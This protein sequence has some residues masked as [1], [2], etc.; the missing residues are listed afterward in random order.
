MYEIEKN[1]L[2]N[3]I[4]KNTY[5][6]LRRKKCYIAGGA[7]TSLFTNHEINDID[8]Y[9]RDKDS[10][11]DLILAWDNNSRRLVFH[12]SKSTTFVFAKDDSSVRVQF[13]NFRFFKDVNEIFDSFDFTVCMGAFDFATE[14]FIFHPDFMRHNAQRILKFNV[15]TSFPIV[16]VFRTQKYQNK[17]YT[18]PSSEF[19]RIILSAM[20]LNIKTW[21]ELED[22]LGGMYGYQ[23]TE[24]F[25]SVEGK[26]FNLSEAI[27][28]FS[29]MDFLYNKIEGERLFDGLLED[30]IDNIKGI[31]IHYIELRNGKRCR[32]STPQISGDT[33][34]QE[35]GH[36]LPP[37]FYKKIELQ[38]FL[39]TEK[40][41]KFVSKTKNPG[42]F[43]SIY[44][45]DFEYKIGEET[46][47]LKFMGLF[48]NFLP[49]ISSS[50]YAKNRYSVSDRVLIEA[51]FD[52]KDIV[53]MNS[54]TVIIKKCI[55]IREVPKEE[56]IQYLI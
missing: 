25:K 1:K 5:E 13:I 35:M 54:T 49:A 32:V 47:D 40:L 15:N 37:P 26:Q 44:K 43:T 11:I 8:V 16:S 45:P 3:Y 55:P 39:G 31:D 46:S 29:N 30:V 18:I 38:E 24:L 50:S 14:E 34:I 51:D 33:D 22:Q 52:V 6:D 56:Y 20:S 48:F 2:L 9:F 17:G 36:R 19:A 41:Y 28:T 21:K 23:Y 7:I 4:G 53:S 27:D 12:S 10:L 42:V